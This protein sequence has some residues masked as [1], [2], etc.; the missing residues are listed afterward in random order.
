[1]ASEE[2]KFRIE[3]KKITYSFGKFKASFEKKDETS[4]SQPFCL[5]YR[6]TKL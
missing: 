5:G 2:E 4:K 3:D 1:M 6:I